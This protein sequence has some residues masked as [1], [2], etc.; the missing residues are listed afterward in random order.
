MTFAKTRKVELISLLTT[1]INS[2][3]ETILEVMFGTE[4]AMKLVGLIFYNAEYESWQV[5]KASLSCIM[6]MMSNSILLPYLSKRINPSDIAYLCYNSL[7]LPDAELQREFISSILCA[8]CVEPQI[9]VKEFRKYSLS[10]VVKK[11]EYFEAK[12]G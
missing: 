1:L 10:A 6:V 5:K 2:A 7:L 11:L 9:Y 4:E 3:S 12:N 8:C